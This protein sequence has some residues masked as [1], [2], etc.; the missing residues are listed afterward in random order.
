LYV[1]HINELREAIDNLNISSIKDYGAVGDGV[2]DDTEAF[3]AAFAIPN[4]SIHIPAGTY[5]VDGINSITVD[6]IKIYGDQKLLSIVKLKDSSTQTG[7]GI[8]TVVS[9]D[10]FNVENITINGNVANNHNTVKGLFIDSSTNFNIN[11]NVF[12]EIPEDAILLNYSG[13]TTACTNFSI[14]NNVFSNIGLSG[15]EILW[16]RNGIIS[17]NS[18]VSC[19]GSGILTWDAASSPLTKYCADLRIS[20][21]YVNRAVPPTYVYGGGAETGYFIGI[22]PADRR[23]LVS[24][25]ICIDNRNTG[26]YDGIACGSYL[27]NTTVI[28]NYV[29]FAA[30]YGI[31][32]GSNS[33]VSGNIVEYAKLAGIVALMD[34][35]ATGIVGCNISNN[36]ISGTGYGGAGA[37]G[38]I[39]GGPGVSNTFKVKVIG[40][41]VYDYAS[42]QTTTYAIYIN[43]TA[44]T[45]DT[46]EVYNNDFKTVLTDSFL[47]VST[48]LTALIT[49]NNLLKTPQKVLSGATPSVLGQEDFMLTNA[50]ATTVTNLTGGYD[51]KIVRFMFSDV[52]TTINNGGNFVLSTSSITGKVL[53]SI[54]FQY[55]L[56]NGKWCEI[57]RCVPA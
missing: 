10:G 32:G 3:N 29:S 37:P 54:T 30:G 34:S 47:I 55:S 2:T 40:N 17:D 31:D 57:A 1:E 42:P 21:N 43:S 48:N 44:A 53:G 36:I 9:T 51:G 16:C 15:M 38:I 7:G 56:A 23:I 4:N 41:T 50:G 19:G 6:N 39:I 26:I 11:N 5:I 14:K 49:A 8:F 52:N 22:G 20:N 45:L 33:V 24:E 28:N 35:D 12:E 46:I 18:I 27:G 25:N 13:S